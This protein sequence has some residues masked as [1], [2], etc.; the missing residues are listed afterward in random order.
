M[1]GNLTVFH[2]DPADFVTYEHLCL[3]HGK[4]CTQVIQSPLQ[5]HM[6][7]VMGFKLVI[8]AVNELGEH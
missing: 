6:A 7:C 3:A 1:E 2:P 4:V 8:R 5:P